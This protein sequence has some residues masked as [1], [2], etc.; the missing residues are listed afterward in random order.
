ML[1]ANDA[2]LGPEWLN[3]PFKGDWADYCK[4][5][6]SGDFLLMYRVDHN[7]IVF[8]RAGTHSGLFEE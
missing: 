4:C 1:I 3:R 7:A 6:I 8:V 5:H 2:P